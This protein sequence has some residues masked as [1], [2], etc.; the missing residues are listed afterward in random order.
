MLV[1]SISMVLMKFHGISEIQEDEV[2]WKYQSSSKLL[3][4]LLN[5]HFQLFL[6]TV[7]LNNKYFR[8]FY[9]YYFISKDIYVPIVKLM[10]FLPNPSAILNFVFFKPFYTF[11]AHAY[12]NQYLIALTFEL[13]RSDI[14]YTIF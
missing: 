9:K 1:N 6:K 14:L 12:V 2:G 4:T 11:I 13:H 3:P 8:L 5:L 7:I 10:G